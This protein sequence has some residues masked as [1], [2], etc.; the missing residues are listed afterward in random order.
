MFGCLSIVRFLSVLIAGF[1]VV[2]STVAVLAAE[3]EVLLAPGDML[4]FD[5]LDDEK[6]PVDLPIAADGTIQ[7]PLLGGVSVAGYTIAAAL[8]HV[9]AIYAERKIFVQPKIALSVAAYRPVFVIGDVRQP[10]SYP[11]QARLTVEKAMGLAGGQITAANGEDPVLARARIHGELEAVEN[12]IIREGLSIARLQAQLNGGDAIRDEDVPESARAYVKGPAADI[13]REVE[14]R[15]LDSDR[16]GFAAQ[17]KI[18]LEN[19]AEAARGQELLV[20]MADKVAKSVEFSR[21]DLERGQGLQQRG[22]KTLTDVSN[23]ERQLTAEESRQLQVMS[24]QS[25]GRREIGTLKRQL[26]DLEQARHMQALVDLQTHTSALIT[27]IGTRRTAEEQLMLLS[28]MT[29]Q[30][31]A[32]NKEVILDFT[33]RRTDAAGN[34]DL[35]ATPATLLQPGDVVIVSIRSTHTNAPLAALQPPAAQPSQ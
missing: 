23:L 30:Q 25:D 17:K 29:A 15:I 32:D 12:T 22:I 33:V 9:N 35:R 10:G 3:P 20:E 6:E 14:M 8:E 34:A 27:A 5:I 2:G 21:A 1:I 16:N 31:M 13:M 18:L 24:Q 11:F 7:A 4:R 26:A 19:I 28:A